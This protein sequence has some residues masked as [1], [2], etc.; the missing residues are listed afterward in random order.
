MTGEDPG[1]LNQNP[2]PLLQPLAIRRDFHRK[3]IIGTANDP[4]R[5]QPRPEHACVGLGFYRN[6][7][8]VPP[9]NAQPATKLLD[10][11]TQSFPK[12]GSALFLRFV[13]L[14]KS[15]RPLTVRALRPR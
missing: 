11:Q 15:I 7:L 1:R 4:W 3:D 13:R 2:H 12:A 8:A 9:L 10:L 14:S 6:H 5:V